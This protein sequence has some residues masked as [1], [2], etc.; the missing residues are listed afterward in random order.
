GKERLYVGEQVLYT[1]KFYRR[2]NTAAAEL[3]K[4][5]WEGFSAESLGE[6]KDYEG[7]LGERRFQV[8]EINFALFP[9]LPGTLEITPAQVVYE[10]IESDPQDPFSRFGFFGGGRRLRGTVTSQGFKVKILPLPQAG[11]PKDFTGLVG[12]YSL[13][14][15]VS[16]K[17]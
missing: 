17:N 9:L 10:A 2:I 8:T 15:E 3:K 4:P 5:T 1:L 16:K 6:Q 14:T 7:I 11:R 13:K 12:S